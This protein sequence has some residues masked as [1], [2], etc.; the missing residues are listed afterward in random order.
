MKKANSQSNKKIAEAKKEYW[1]TFCSNEVYDHT[2]LSKVWDKMKE[3]KNGISLPCYPITESHNAF[4]SDEEK[5]EIFAD[6]F[7]QNSQH[8]GLSPTSRAYRVKEEQFSMYNDPLPENDLWFNSPITYEE[9]K[10]AISSL[11]D[12]KSSVGIDAISNQLIKHLPENCLIFLHNIFQ[13]CWESGTVPQVWK[14]SIVIPIAKAGKPKRN[15]NSYRP[16]SLTSHTSKLMEKIVLQRLTTYCDKNNVIPVNQAGFRK[17][18]S[19]MEHLVK[20]TTQIKHQFSRR[21]SVL[22]TFF[23]VKKAYD[24][25]WHKR[26]LFK[27]KSAGISGNMYQYIKAFLEKRTIQARIGV[28]YSNPRELNMGIPQGSV[29]APLLFNILIQDLPKVLSNRVVLAQYAD[30]ICM[31]MDV[32]LKKT[33]RLREQNHI[34]KL[35]QSD[36]NNLGNYMF[37]N[38]LALS[39][40]KTNMM[41]FNSGDN[42]KSKPIFKLSGEILEYKEVVKFLGVFLTSKLSWNIHFDYMLT[43]ARKTINFLK[44]VSRLPWGMDTQNLVHL[45]MALV[46]SKL[47][48]GQEVFF[49]APKYLLQKIQSADCKALK[50]ALGVPMHASNKQTYTVAGLLPLDEYRKLASAKFVVRCSSMPDNFIGDE[51]QIRSDV[52]FPKRA[53]DISSQKTI[54]TYTSALITESGIDLRDVSSKPLYSPLPTW[55]MLKANYDI[56]YYEYKKDDNI[57]LTVSSA[58]IHM[59]E[60]YYNHLHIF[61]DGSVINNIAGA[62]FTIPSLK[63]QKSIYIGKN[64]SIFTAELIGII[65]ALEYLVDFP[66]FKTKAVFFVD[67]KAV[68]YAMESFSLKTRP[69][70]IIQANHLIHSLIMKGIDVSLCWIPSH[71]GIYGNESADKSAK[72]GIQHPEKS[73]KIS[74]P[75]S[76]KET[77]SLLEKA[78]RTKLTETSKL[79]S[80]LQKPLY[81]ASKNMSNISTYFSRMVSTVFFRIYLN[82]LK[83]KFCRNVKCVC[84]ESFSLHHALFHC[85]KMCDFLPKNFTEKKL[86]EDSFGEIISNERLL[87]DI[88][89][90]MLHSPVSALL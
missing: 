65:Q 24:Q 85:K 5:A 8:I 74:V 83:T 15:K 20:L 84:G 78:S 76:V 57:N 35:Y 10:T 22:A 12:K 53:K 25:V 34:R 7:A 67:S 32:T 60:K 28:N 63:V 72:T 49:S 45:S 75:L 90:S 14:K 56:N 36:L 41:L 71:V 23:D 31:W 81:T 50:I 62:G 6:V 69:E 54:T 66:K 38:G 33:T 11:H 37:E 27:L 59:A 58:R 77:Y 70:L 61:S 48:Y 68:L 88:S 87:Y 29:I 79:N 47:T 64:V 82:A 39:T 4:P 40:E 17:G 2:D 51:L 13:R 26:L 3:V 86:K 42:P 9:L 55:E 43:K 16:I 80:K 19:T 21:K 44:I 18:R 30:D 52:D 1:S 73:T 46:R 89:I